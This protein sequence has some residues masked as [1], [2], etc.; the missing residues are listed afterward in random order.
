[1]VLSESFRSHGIDPGLYKYMLNLNSGPWLFMVNTPTRGLQKE[2]TVKG[3]WK[4]N[5]HLG[6]RLRNR[7]FTIQIRKKRQ[8]TR[9]LTWVQPPVLPYVSFFFRE[10]RG[11]EPWMKEQDSRNLWTPGSRRQWQWRSTS[12]RTDT[13]TDEDS[14]GSVSTQGGLLFVPFECGPKQN[15]SPDQK[16]SGRRC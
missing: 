3:P 1:M 9:T 4:T 10:I 12:R 6:E 11:I 7:S 13:T 8:C 16:E 15:K 5:G 2:E 14:K